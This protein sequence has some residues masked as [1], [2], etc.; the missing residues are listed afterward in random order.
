MTSGARSGPTGRRRRSERSSLAMATRVTRRG[1]NGEMRL[2]Q[3]EHPHAPDFVNERRR[4]RRQ[5]HN[6]HEVV[7]LKVAHLDPLS[8][9]H[10]CPSHQPCHAE[11][12]L[13]QGSR[14][15]R[16]LGGTLR[17]TS[18]R[19]PQPITKDGIVRAI[20]ESK[21][22]I[23]SQPGWAPL[24]FDVWPCSRNA[25]PGRLVDGP[26]DRTL[27]RQLDWS[28]GS[29][30]RRSMGLL[31]EGQMGMMTLGGPDRRGASRSRIAA[32]SPHGRAQPIPPRPPEITKRHRSASSS[33]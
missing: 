12:R 10:A 25:P 21:D 13:S 6:V 22:V 14:T 4:A 28:L 3:S 9:E 5:E 11:R 31:W 18:D 23:V 20:S 17:L 24:P 32:A 16:C 30:H 29:S 2:V 33:A 8:A 19:I 26:Y 15:R 7:L 1:N 27:T